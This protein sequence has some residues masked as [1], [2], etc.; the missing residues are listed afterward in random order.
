MTK[1]YKI[2]GKELLQLLSDSR[3]LTALEC[4]GVDNWCG[5]D[6][7]YE[8]MDESDEVTTEDLPQLYEEIK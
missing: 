8:G 5:Y 2:E 7:R 3:E 1:F 6:E 4:A